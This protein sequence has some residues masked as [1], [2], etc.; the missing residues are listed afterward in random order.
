VLPWSIIAEGFEHEGERILYGSIPR[1]IHRPKQ[2]KGA[3]LSIK[4]TV[5][6]PDKQA[7]YDD[8]LA[9]EANHFV[10]CF[11]G[12]DPNT[13][14]NQLLCEAHRLGAPLI[15]FYGLEPGIYEPLWP[16]YVTMWSASHLHCLI[17]A[18]TA[19]AHL[20]GGVDAH[21]AAVRRAYAT[22]EAKVRLHQHAFR[23]LVLRAYDTRCTICNLPRRELLEAA[24]ILPDRD[25]RGRPEVPNGLAL[26]QLHHSAFDAKLLG[27]RPDHRIEIAPQLLLERDGPVLEHALKGFHGESIH[28]PKKRRDRP[29]IEYLEECYEAFLRAG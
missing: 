17:A 29:R 15:Y 8:Q 25:E 21:V 11:Q 27:I 9:S 16:V 5:P 1:G 14:D 12:D 28:L 23:R 24:H 18:D 26:C 7:R 4:T 6:K 13:Y 19:G 10:Y 2:M 20:D 22:T 3:A